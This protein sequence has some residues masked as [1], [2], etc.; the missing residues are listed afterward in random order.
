[1]ILYQ[2]DVEAVILR[3]ETQDW[4][5]ELGTYGLKDQ[6]IRAYMLNPREF[7]VDIGQRGY[8]VVGHIKENDKDDLEVSR[9]E[10]L[11]RTNYLCLDTLKACVYDLFRQGYIG[12][13]YYIVDFNSL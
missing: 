1:M 13:G 5:K 8:L 4:M 10:T 9:V 6:I 12:E 7:R 2:Q 11:R 3:W